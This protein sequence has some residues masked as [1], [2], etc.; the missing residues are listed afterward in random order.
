MNITIAGTGYVGLVVGL[1]YAE[2]GH[3]VTCYDVD[4]EKIKLLNSGQSPIYEKDI[5]DLLERN[6]NKGRISFTT[7]ANK[8]YSYPEVVFIGVGTPEKENGEANLEYVMLVCDKIAHFLKNNCVV[9]VKSTVP[10]GTNDVIEHYIKDRLVHN[11]QIEVVSNPEFLAQGSAV[12][13]MFN[14]DRIIIGTDS[15]NARNIMN[16]LYKDFNIPIVNVGRRSAEMIKYASNDFLA[17]KISYMNEIANLC[18]ILGC[19]VILTLIGK[20]W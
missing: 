18:E 19:F 4:E 20:K 13:N 15:D 3:N 1:C 16:E 8:A 2:V 11:I 9:V 6:L 14:A 10:I 7:D 12:E 5:V 17:L